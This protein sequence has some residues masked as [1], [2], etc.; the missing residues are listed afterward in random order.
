MTVATRPGL[1]LS[2]AVLTLAVAVWTIQGDQ[3]VRVGSHLLVYGVAFGAYLIG[4]RFATGLADRGVGL[5][6]AVGLVW[7]I[8]LVAAPPLLSDD[9]YRYV[10]EGRIQLHR[11][12][13]YS[14][15]DR[16]EAEKWIPLRDAVW[17]QVS[18]KDYTAVYPPLAQLTAAAVVAIRDSVT[19][20]KSF[21][22]ACEA[23]TIA[24]LARI[25]RGRGLP[26]HRLLVL[27][28]SPLAL[29]EI[30]GSGHNDA[31]GMLLATAGFAA[32]EAGRPLSS[33]AAMALGFQAKL[34]PGLIGAAW[35]RRYRP[36]DV[37]AG[38]VVAAALVAPYA[39]AGA[40]LWRSLGKY[41]EFWR[42]NE[43][44]FAVVATLGGS[45]GAAAKTMLAVLAGLA[46]AL[47]L[48]R[49]EEAAAALA[50]VVTWL[51]LGPNVLPWY[52][53]WLLPWLVLRDCPAV[54]LFTGTVG[55][56]YLVYPAWQSGGPWRLGW[57]V[58][59]L[60]YGPCVVVAFWSWARP[61][62]R[63]SGP[64]RPS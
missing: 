21:A 29:V 2:G 32:L 33:A 57:G 20:M 39:S 47:A 37:I 23:L 17:R 62:S 12:N 16:P 34:L 3:T 19:A 26:L 64:G 4:L 63:P 61:A 56:A 18:H 1:A 43:T 58:R 13:P 40:G 24:L 50:L 5:A 60:E 11:G 30:A 52:A 44:A 6:L 22:V 53:L 59:A 27:A 54:L 45:H 31:L 49:V 48:L 51:V 28:W 41:G 25:L 8:A 38:A 35:G 7:R 15:S 14:W 46:G 42:F 36:R 55:L 9:V 10:W